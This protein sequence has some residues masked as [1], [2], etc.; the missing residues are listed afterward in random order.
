MARLI[1]HRLTVLAGLTLAV[2]F[3]TTVGISATRGRIC[4]SC[5]RGRARATTTWNETLGVDPAQAPIVDSP[6]QD[7]THDMEPVRAQSKRAP[8]A[9][10]C[11][12]GK[13]P[14]LSGCFAAKPCGPANTCYPREGGCR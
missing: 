12:D 13:A 11:A 14:G 4:V 9:P 1:A 8:T 3:M 2:P 6:G 10:C 5:P 7:V